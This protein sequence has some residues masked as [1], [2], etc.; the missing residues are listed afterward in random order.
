MTSITSAIRNYTRPLAFALLLAGSSLMF[1][2]EATPAADNTKVNARDQGQPAT[3]ADQQKENRSDVELTQQIR[4]ELMKDKGLSTYAHN[5][6]IVTEN[7][8]V[9][10]RG[11]VRTDEEKKTIEAKAA[12]VSGK[13]VKSE[14]SVAPER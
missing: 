3:T 7:G 13:A 5:V 1:G 8:V 10:L 11:P 9:T 12:E 2:Q 4:R 6:K 14:L